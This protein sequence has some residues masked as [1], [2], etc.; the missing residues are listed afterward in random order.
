L[1]DEPAVTRHPFD[2]TFTAED[3]VAN[4][5]TQSGVKELPTEA[6]AELLER[7]HRRVTTQGGT[8]TVHH[9]A[10]VTIATPATQR[11]ASL[12]GTM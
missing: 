12:R 3:H 5:A 7:I 10:V 8:L 4:L 1:F 11:A 9:L 6:Q 2:V